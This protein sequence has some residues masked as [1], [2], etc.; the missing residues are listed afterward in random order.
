M[1]E[2]AGA[3]VQAVSVFKVGGATTTSRIAAVD[4]AVAAPQPAPR[5]AAQRPARKL[6]APANKA[7]APATERRERVTAV[8]A[9][10][11][12]AEF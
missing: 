6:A 9:K 4:P 5:V 8:A 10:E 1:R 7:G 3:L 11:E 12:W 2:Q